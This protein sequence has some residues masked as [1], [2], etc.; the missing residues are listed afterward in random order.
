MTIIFSGK[1]DGEPM[2]VTWTDGELSGDFAAV[3]ELRSWMRV[4]LGKP[5]VE[6]MFVANDSIDDHSKSW[7]SV[8]LLLSFRVFDL[9]TSNFES[10]DPSANVKADSEAIA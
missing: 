4:F 10:D 9:G 8:S 6:G 2:A 1:I 5:I 7:R 3:E